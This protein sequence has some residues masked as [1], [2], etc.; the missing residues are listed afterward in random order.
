MMLNIIVAEALI[1]GSDHFDK[2]AALVVSKLRAVGMAREGYLANIIYRLGHGCFLRT[3]CPRFVC[4]I[5][6]LADSK[7]DLDS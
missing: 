4:I 2:S 7:Q 3:S 1:G 6:G 5:S